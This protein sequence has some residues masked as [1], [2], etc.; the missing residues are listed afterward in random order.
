MMADRL[1]GRV[2]SESKLRGVTDIGDPFMDS[3]LVGGTGEGGDGQAALTLVAVDAT[4]LSKQARLTV[5]AIEEVLA[6]LRDEVPEGLSL[7]MTGSAVVGHDTNEASNSSIDTTTIATIALVVAILLLVYRSPLLALIPLVAIALSVF[8]SL[9]GL[10]AL[11]WVPGL[12]F[13][14][15]NVTKVF[16]IVV[17]FGAGTDYCLFLIARYREERARGLA[18]PEALGVAIRQVGAALVASAGTVIVG[19]GMLWFSSFAKIQYSG[20]SIALSLSVALAAA[21]TVAPVLLKWFGNA[22]DWPFG[23]GRRAARER[24]QAGN[25]DF[26]EEAAEAAPRALGPRGRRGRR[27]GRALILAA[28][29]LPMAALAVLG[30]RARS[31]YGQLADLPADAPSKVG[32][33]LIRDYFPI[34][35]LGPATLLIADPGRRL[36][37][38]R[39]PPGRRVADRPARGDA[40]GRRG[41]LPDPPARRAA[42]ADA[43][44][45]G[46]NAAGQR[47]AADGPGGF[48]RRQLDRRRADRRDRPSAATGPPSRST[49]AAGRPIRPTSATSPGSTCSLDLDPFSEPGLNALDAML[50]EVEG[51]LGRPRPA[52]LAGAEFGYAGST[53]QLYDLRA[54]DRRRPAPDVRPGDARRLRDPGRPAASARDQPLPDRHGGA[55]LPR[56]ARAHR[57]VFRT[58]ARGARALARARL[59]GQLLPLRDPGGRRRGLQYLPDVAGGR[60]GAEPSAGRRPPAAPWRRPAA[61]S[62]RAA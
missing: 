45:R 62:A 44:R 11:I 50:A 48:L 20:P 25:G 12:E 24:R 5:N 55:R 46:R 8:I 61:S 3:I 18:I 52:P 22:V 29:L 16:V 54:V 37:D 26:D 40:R 42:G 31:N 4:Y 59:E 57:L 43:R 49:S 21:L 23:R 15:I 7:A 9:K 1:E 34:G 28:C 30:T 10:P 39:G 58:L 35:E 19:L 56:D 13:Q 2:G 53:P 14:V 41:P 17:L 36:P 33:R 47:R 60:G 51:A 38:R 6:G 32:A 27:A